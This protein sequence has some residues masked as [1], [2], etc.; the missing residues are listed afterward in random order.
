MKRVVARPLFRVVLLTLVAA[1]ALV[2][3]TAAAAAPPAPAGGTFTTTSAVFNSARA[4]DGNTIV[5]LTAH[6]AYTGTFEGTSVVRGILVLHADGSANFHDVETFTGTVNGVP[7]TVTFNLSGGSDAAGLYHG[8][9]VIVSGAG[10]LTDLHGVLTQ[11]GTV[12]PP[13]Q[14]PAGTYTGQIH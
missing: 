14:P 12:H 13:A 10:G 2:G 9:A 11:T 6:V 7:G 1:L 5:D 4:A 8:T 3:V